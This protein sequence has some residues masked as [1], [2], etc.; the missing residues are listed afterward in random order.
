MAKKK[1]TITPTTMWMG[2]GYKAHLMDDST[3][4]RLVIICPG[5]QEA[6]ILPRATAEQW[7]TPVVP[8]RTGLPANVKITRKVVARTP[9]KKSEG[10]IKTAKKSVRKK[11]KS[12]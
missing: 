3:D 1:E 4:S 10:E 9:V 7:N 12:K 11:T 8:K 2:C 6:I 5:G